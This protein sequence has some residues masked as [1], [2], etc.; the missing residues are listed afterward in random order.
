MRKRRIEEVKA[1]VSEIFELPK[2]IVLNLPRISM[3]GNNQMLVENHRGVIEYTPQKIRLN[4][5][6]GVIRVEGQDMNLKNIAADDILI[7]GV[8]KLVEF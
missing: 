7:T 4:S 3:I 1:K 2:D 8:I 5:T 6:I